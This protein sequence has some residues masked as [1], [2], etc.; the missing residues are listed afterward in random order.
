MTC[1]LINEQA[2]YI[3]SA[4]LNNARKMPLRQKINQYLRQ[5]KKMGI[6]R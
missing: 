5:I 2:I 4:R 3:A 6:G 1:P